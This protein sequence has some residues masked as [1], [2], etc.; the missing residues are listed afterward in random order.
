MAT[1]GIAV[2]SEM[3]YFSADV[4]DDVKQ[5]MLG[6]YPD[7]KTESDNIDM[8]NRSG[9][10]VIATRRLT[11]EAWWKNY[12]NPLKENIRIHKASD[13]KIMQTVIADTETEM[14][15]FEKYSSD[16]G[17]TFYIMKAV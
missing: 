2:I 8:I 3:N 6:L 5:Y 17:Y 16:Y 1:G 13:D 10:K 12:Y 15:M 9:F 7:I 14:E 4:P 11:E